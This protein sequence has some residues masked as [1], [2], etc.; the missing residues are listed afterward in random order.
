TFTL[1]PLPVLPG[2]TAPGPSPAW[3]GP[4]RPSA[5]RP[6][7]PASAAAALVRRPRRAVVMTLP[8]KILLHTRS[9]VGPAPHLR[10]VPPWAE[11]R[12]Q[13]VNGT[14]TGR[15]TKPARA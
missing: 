2:S 3:A 12:G 1:Y 7:A 15:A 10:T 13:A 14:C 5:A 6:R 11:V 8:S 9:P 4:A